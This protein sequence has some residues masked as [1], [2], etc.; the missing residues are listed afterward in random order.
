MLENPEEIA[1]LVK[2]T[3]AVSTDYESPEDVDSLIAKT[4]PYA[5]KWKPMADE[6]WKDIE[7]PKDIEYGKMKDAEKAERAARKATEA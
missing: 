2:E 3:G 4:K 5:E 1:R 6:L 7:R